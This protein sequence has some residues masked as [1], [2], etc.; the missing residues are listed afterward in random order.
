MKKHLK[1][2]IVGAILFGVLIIITYMMKSDS[3]LSSTQSISQVIEDAISVYNGD[4]KYI[5]LFILSMVP[6]I[7]IVMIIPVAVAIGMDLVLVSVVASAGNILSI[8][9]T[10]WIYSLVEDRFPNILSRLY[11]TEDSEGFGNVYWDKYGIPGLIMTSPWLIGTRG[12]VL[13][14][15][16]TG[17]NKDS[18]LF[19]MTISVV[20]W[21]ITMT[22]VSHYGLG[23][24]DY[25][26]NSI[27]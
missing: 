25:I 19:W 18:V 15:L 5:V 20:I 1:K 21:S 14:A 22:C 12:S 10:V 27:H 7:E 6:I 17:S 24:F 8:L 4:M 9:A 13:L 2:L 26:T 11:Q 16:Y 23:M 3:L